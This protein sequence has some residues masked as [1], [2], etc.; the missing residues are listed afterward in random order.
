MKIRTREELNEVVND[1]VRDVELYI[2]N[3][4]T[5]YDRST[6]PLIRNYA[7]K[8]SKGNFNKELA[9]VGFYHVVV[10]GLREY[11]KEFCESSFAWHKLL[12][13]S[14][15]KMVASLLL[16]YYMEQIEWDANELKNK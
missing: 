8:M 4:G 15:R 13:V 2:E 14:E 6:A 10:D 11:A 3:C 16:D 12:T 9:K 1:A 5:V 7:R